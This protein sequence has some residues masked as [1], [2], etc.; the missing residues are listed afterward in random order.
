MGYGYGRTMRGGMA[1]ACD[2]C[3]E[4]E[5][6]TRKR[7]CRF[8]VTHDGHAL[9]YCSAPALCP[10]CWDRKGKGRGVHGERCRKGAETSQAREDAKVARL[11]T[12]DARVTSAIRIEEDWTGVTFRDAEGRETLRLVPAHEYHERN[13]DHGLWLSD[14]PLTAPWD[15]KVTR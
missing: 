3:G 7:R 1:L 12:G 13:E 9:P 14:Y 8:T 10:D 11:A 4:A 15:G 6:R 2:G 5:G